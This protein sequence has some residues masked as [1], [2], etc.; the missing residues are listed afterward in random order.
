[1]NSYFVNEINLDPDK[2]FMYSDPFILLTTAW[3]FETITELFNI[4]RNITGDG[5]DFYCHM[6][7]EFDYNPSTYGIVNES[8]Y[9]NVVNNNPFNISHPA[10]K[11]LR[12]KNT[13]H[14]VSYSSH[15]LLGEAFRYIVA[16]RENNYTE[17]ER[18][19]E[20]ILN[21]TKGL[22]FLSEVTEN[23]CMARMAMPDTPISRQF[24][25][26]EIFVE[27]YKGNHLFTKKIYKK[28]GKNYTYYL[29]TG[30]SIDLYM[31]VLTAFG[32]IYTF[33]NDAE[34]REII[35]KTVD[36]M[37]NYYLK[38][39][40][41]FVD[42]D[43]KTHSAGAE[44][45]TGM[46]AVDPMYNILFLRVGAT[47]NPS[48]WKMIYE[49]YVY[50]RIFVKKVGK[51]TNLGISAIFNWIG[52]YFNV[53]LH[54][55]CASILTLLE[56]DIH[57]KSI[58]FENF[59]KPVHEVNK[60]HRNPWYDGLYLLASGVYDFSKY[61]NLINP[62]NKRLDYSWN[63]YINRSIGDSL[64]RFAL[65][66]YPYR[67]FPHANGLDSYNDDRFSPI[68][69]APYPNVKILDW[70]EIVDYNNP[71]QKSIG[72]MVPINQMWNL[73]IPTDW[74][75]SSTWMWENFPFSTNR[76]E[77]G[78]GTVGLIP[79]SYTSPYWIARYLNL[80]CVKI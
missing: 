64:M 46:P 55:L 13:G 47:I 29:E 38:T 70:R 22:S 21:V 2:D 36:R 9:L 39:G 15:T 25:L 69:N 27:D 1:M 78:R 4:P 76:G 60:Y 49:K 75:D 34:I 7:V 57:L 48:K 5:W 12:W 14:T 77:G 58:Y 65:R 10:N 17:L 73:P 45:I 11:I 32:V 71:I 19:R 33:V 44:A 72:N 6:D 8:T 54:S 37:L 41:K 20:Q 26:S 74:H 62:P 50:D 31:A 42:F 23:G 66:K 40:W 80:D 30:T 52:G 59:L 28:D 56:D 3:N 24:M 43:G 51:H 67:D 18:T 68:P 61:E 79:G 16:L 53:H 35:Q 63:Y